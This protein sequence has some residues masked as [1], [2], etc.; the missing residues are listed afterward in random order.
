M[1]SYRFKSGLGDRIELNGERY[2][3]FGTL[4]IQRTYFILNTGRIKDGVMKELGNTYVGLYRNGIR[5]K[6]REASSLNQ[7][8]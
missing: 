4:D 1:Q 5:I 3:S 7:L 2:I 6:I 8:R